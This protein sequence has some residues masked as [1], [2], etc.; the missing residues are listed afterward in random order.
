MNEMMEFFS[1]IGKILQ[2]SGFEE[3]LYQ[4]E[5]CSPKGIKVFDLENILIGVGGFMNALWRQY[6]RECSSKL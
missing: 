4:V 3:V 6:L 1:V 2:S 5:L